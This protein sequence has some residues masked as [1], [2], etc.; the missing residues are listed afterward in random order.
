MKAIEELKQ[1]YKNYNEQM[2]AIEELKQNYKNYNESLRKQNLTILCLEQQKKKLK[3]VVL[4]W[5]IH[6]GN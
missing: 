2:K 1:N 6:K 4:R 5:E 3:L